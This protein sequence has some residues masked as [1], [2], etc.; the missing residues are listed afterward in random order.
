MVNGTT[1]L[2]VYSVTE[3]NKTELSALVKKLNAKSRG[4]Y[5]AYL[6]HDLPKNT[7]YFEN[8]RIADIIVE[9]I[10]PT[11]FINS[12][13]VTNYPKGMHGYDPHLVP[14]MGALF[15]ANGPSF[16]QG[17]T[18]PEFDNIHVFPL[19]NDLLELPLLESIDGKLEVLSP[20]LKKN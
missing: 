12:D 4:Q 15:I 9:T 6:K 2:Q 20:T 7:H 19:L 10:A 13:D 5:I 3:K 14:E 16:K 8:N 18:I 11:V 17:L 1:Q